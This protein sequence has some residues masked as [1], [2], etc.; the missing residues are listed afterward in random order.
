DS[1]RE[2]IS[3]GSSSAVLQRTHES[4]TALRQIVSSPGVSEELYEAARRVLLCLDA[5]TDLL[6]TPAEEDPQLRLLQ[7]EC[8]AT[9]LATLSEL[10]GKVESENKPLKEKP[11]ALRCLSSLQDGLHTAQLLLTSSPQLIEHLGHTHQHQE[12][13]SNQLCILDEFEVG[14][15]EMFPSIQDAPSLEQCVLGRHLRESLGEKVKLQQASRSLLQG[16]TRLLE[17]G[18]ECITG[19]QR[20]Q[21]H[22]RGQLQAP[23]CRDKKLLRVLRSQ[24]AF[25]QHLFQREPG[26]LRCQEDERVQLVVRAT[27][28]QHQALE[29][30]VASQRRTQEWTRW[31]DNCRGLGELL[32]DVDVFISSGE[33]EG[34][35]ERLAQQRQEAC[36]QTQVQLEESRA[37]LGLILDQG[38]RLQ[39]EPQFAAS[40]C[41][42]GGALELRWQSACRR[43]EQERKRCTDIQDSWARFQTDFAAV[44]EWL[45]GANKHQ[46]TWSNLADTSDL[47]QECVHNNL[48]KLLD[49]SM[50]IEAVSVQRAS[51]ARRANQLLHLREADCPGLRAQL[52]QLEGSWSQLTSDLSKIQDRLQQRLLAAWPPVELLS[53]LED[54]LK[55]LQAQTD[56]ERETVA[57][58]EDA[59]QITKIL[60]QYREL[61]A[62]LLNGQLLLDFLCQS[63]PPVLGVD[64]RALRSERTMYAEKLGALRLQWLLLQRELES[65]ID[66]AE[67]MH[68][69]CADREKR[70]QR[71]HGW[72]EQQE[73]TLNRWKQ[74][75]SLTLARE[76]LLKWEAAVSKVKEVAAALQELKATRVHVEKGEDHPCDISFSDRTERVRQA[77]ADLN[78]QMEALRP[79]VQQSVEQWSCFESDLR[80]VSLQT[81]RGRCALQHQPLF[82]LKQAEGH[83]DYLQQLQEK[84]GKGEELWATVDKSYQMLVKTLHPGTTQALDDQMRG[85]QKRWRAVV[86]ELEDEHMKTAETL[87]LWQEFTLLSDRCSSQR[88]TLQLQWEEI[89]RSPP[90]QDT[91]TTL[92][93][94]EKL[95][96][97]AEDLQSSVGDVLADSKPLIGRL[98]PLAAHFI[99]SE[100]RLL[101]RDVV[102]L[103]QAMSGKKKSLQ[104][105][106]DQREL[107]RNRLE[108]IEKQTQNTQQKLKTSLKDPDSVKQVLLEL[109]DVFPLLVDIR[110]MSVY[111]SLSDQERQR[112]HTLS[113][114]WAESMTHASNRNSELQAVCQR[115]QSFQEKCK[116]LTSLKKKLED[117]SLSKET[118]R[119]SSLQEMLTVHQTLEAETTIG[120]QLLQA[121]LCDAVESMEKETGQKRS[122]LM[123]QVTCVRQSWLQSVALAGERRSF[124]K[125]QLGEWRVYRRGSKLLWKLLRDVGPLLPPAGPA[126]CSLQQLRSCADD[127]QC[128]EEALALHSTV[129]SQTLEAGRRLCETTTESECQALQDAW[130]RTGTLL[131]SR[132]GLV[133]TTLQKWSQCQERL[134]SITS[135]LDDLNTELKPPLA[136][137]ETHIQETDFSLQRLTGGFREVATMKTDLTQYVAAGDSALLEQQLEQLHVQWEELCTKVSLRRQ[138]I[139]DRLNAWTI[140]NDKNKEFCDWLTQMEN[141]VCHSGDLSIEEMV[142]KLKKDCMEEINL[143]SENKSH[144]KQLGEQ[145]LSASDE[146]KQTQVHGSLQEVNQRWHN[147]FHN[148]EARVKKL[149]ET[150]AA[151]QQLDKN[152]SNLRSWLCRIEADLSRPVTYSVCH[153][154]EIQRRLAEEQE[155]QRDIEQHTEG[156]ASVLSLCDVLLR[157]EDAA[158]GN[159]AESDSL[160]ETSHSLDQRWRA[161]CSMALDRRLR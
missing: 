14:Q 38:K 10:L 4:I 161:V 51:A 41:Q 101:S 121:L 139:A 149:K 97:A 113:R 71:L 108:A 72:V 137:D 24:L 60:H 83:V 92:Q 16:I 11:E 58:A 2:I 48:I 1:E 120:H 7:Q 20:G 43:T 55:K 30:E 104:D 31:E 89:R 128:V 133:R 136:D 18:E 67:Q 45:L 39:T 159:E 134:T 148:I 59:A 64:V 17:L 79:A 105:D 126:V 125:E 135:E 21:V 49:F 141:K 6:L 8:V 99:Q 130:D 34:D 122:Q 68:H 78:Q 36:Q 98:E 91:Q 86:Q 150:L 88:Q 46:K 156:V 151:V 142:E 157:D 145:L 95:R 123:A 114:L 77:C 15:S 160:Q 100:T 124:I 53:D 80:E 57:K 56:Q 82:S 61:K 76:A 37:V 102:L 152:I 127:Y 26:A 85:E 66:E 75:T 63:G 73:K 96:D 94:L 9:E 40:V 19:G 109:R 107:F 23:L 25:V 103:S 131:E 146:A 106:L 13:A 111:L 81:T 90:Q 154:Q 129:C 138:E 132:G 27:A 153:H 147:L 42:A 65:Q 84:A 155:L 5:L 62:G 118:Q 74:P 54:R 50:E 87:S 28:L 93:S 22:N 70:L 140:F 69:T 117:E 12:P 158:G 112:V 119:F 32:D 44:S 33:P 144:L 3:T 143:F 110:E 52:T 115:S 116:N 47:S 29:Q 35:D